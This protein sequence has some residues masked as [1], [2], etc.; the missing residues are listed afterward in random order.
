MSTSFRDHSPTHISTQLFGSF[1]SEETAVIIP[2]FSLHRDPR[3]FSPQ[4]NDVIP[5]RWLTPSPQDLKD[6]IEYH[7]DREAFIP[8]SYGPANC[9]GKVFALAELRC[10]IAMLVRSFDMQHLVGPGSEDPAALEEKVRV[11]MEGL[12]DRFVFEKPELPVYMAV[13]KE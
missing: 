4:P 12:K 8:F 10:V 11:W 2:A 6:G 1:I 13:R 3:Y 5:E 9:A 7:T